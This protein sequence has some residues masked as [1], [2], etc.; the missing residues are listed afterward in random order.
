MWSL[1]LEVEGQEVGFVLGNGGGNHREDLGGYRF[2][3]ESWSGCLQVA[4]RV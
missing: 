2:R 3:V 4:L 1:G